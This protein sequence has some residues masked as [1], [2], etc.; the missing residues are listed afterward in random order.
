MP[1]RNATSSDVT[2]IS[3]VFANA[4]YNE[5]LNA[6]LF[7]L[8]KQYP[9]DYVRSWHQ[10]V[11]EKYWS[12]SSVFLVSYEPTDQDNTP[13]LQRPIR[14][15]S[16][17]TYHHQSILSPWRIWRLDPRRLISPIIS[18]YY[19]CLNLVFP[20]KAAR[21]PSPTDP[22]PLTKANFYERLGPF[23]DKFFSEPPHRRNHWELSFLGV[24][25]KYQGQGVASE[26][27]QMGLQRAKE[28][29]L[30]AVVVA[31]PG[32]E[33]FYHRQA[34]KDLVAMASTTEDQEGKGRPNPLKERGVGGGAI[35][36]T[37]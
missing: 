34:F 15:V 29:D 37:R 5:Q 16:I 12:Y 26:L 4:F 7:P 14:G 11:V 17:W 36:W 13:P 8:R 23:V 2:A 30:P 32:L 21:K 24:D 9:A 10:K 22:D 18:I 1:I 25:P 19:R 6:H 35:I 33:D 20:N 27:V 3:Q 28:E 31:A